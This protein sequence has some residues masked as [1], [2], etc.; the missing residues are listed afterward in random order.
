[1]SFA[2]KEN[3]DREIR[4]NFQLRQ[5]STAECFNVKQRL[6]KSLRRK[7]AIQQVVIQQKSI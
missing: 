4:L 3:R 6:R 5:D 7:N 1:L 2:C